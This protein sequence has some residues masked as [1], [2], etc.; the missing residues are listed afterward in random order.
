MVQAHEARAGC[1]DQHRGVL[2]RDSKRR[3]TLRRNLGKVCDR[4]PGADGRDVGE[5]AEEG[6]EPLGLP[7]GGDLVRQLPEEDRHA[8]RAPELRHNVEEGV[9]PVADEQRHVLPALVEA[10]GDRGVDRQA[11]GVQDP[12]EDAVEGQEGQGR[13]VEEGLLAEVV[14]DPRVVHHEH[15]G[16][17]KHAVDLE[18]R[19]GLGAAGADHEGILGVAD[20]RVD[21]DDHE[22]HHRHAKELGHFPAFDGE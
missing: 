2:E 20:R 12:S 19:D 8:D 4:L 16:R 15:G 13:H 10:R 7:H 5:L 21:V 22:H 18:E 9:A 1:Q 3:V 6:V 11:V 17:G 14:G